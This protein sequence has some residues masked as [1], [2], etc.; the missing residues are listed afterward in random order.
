[1]GVPIR[2]HCLVDLVT[3]GGRYAARVEEIGQGQAVMRLF[4][5]GT[6]F[7]AATDTTVEAVSPAGLTRLTGRAVL[8]DDGRTVRF[9]AD[10]H[11]EGGLQR[12]RF[13]RVPVDRECVIFRRNGSSC[14]AR[15][16]DVSTGGMLIYAADSFE[17]EQVVRFTLPRGGDEALITGHARC[18]RESVGGAHA[19]EF[20]ALSAAALHRLR[21]LV[22]CAQRMDHVA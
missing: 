8:D 22:A 10:V 20:S 2:D 19:F 16:V 3:A 13:P 4:E 5:A 6:D 9:V 17:L 12:R 1:M 7:P 21:E 11:D 14:A 18:I 15:V